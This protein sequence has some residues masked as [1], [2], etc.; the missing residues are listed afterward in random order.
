MSTDQEQGL[1]ILDTALW[2]IAHRGDCEYYDDEKSR[3]TPCDCAHCIARSALA[4]AKNW[5]FHGSH[6]A[7][8]QGGHFPR[9]TKMQ[10]AWMKLATGN[11][12]GP[13]HLLQKAILNGA[14]LRKSRDR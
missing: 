1:R 7:R 3:P 11:Q 13:D 9:E 6:Y 12:G 14:F 2:R 5:R 4:A 10:A 8:T